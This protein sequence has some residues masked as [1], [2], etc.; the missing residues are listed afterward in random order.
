MYQIL[1]YTY[2]KAKALGVNVKPSTNSTKKIDVYK[3]GKKVASV[4]GLGYGD[5]PTF[6]Q[7]YGKS[8]ANK[9][10]KLYKQRHE[11]DRHKKGS[12]GYYADQLLW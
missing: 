1:P 9:K 11:K 2:K 8:Y 5:Y 7:S 12:A 4:G 10:R 3:K 6:L